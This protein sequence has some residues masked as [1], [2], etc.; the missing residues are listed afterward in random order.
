MAEYDSVFP[1]WAKGS[2]TRCRLCRE[3][4]GDDF[5]EEADPTSY[6]TLADLRRIAAEMGEAGEGWLAEGDWLTGRTDGIDRLAHMRHVWSSLR[7]LRVT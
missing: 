2:R 3:V 5:P 6:V 4:Y 1:G 7:R